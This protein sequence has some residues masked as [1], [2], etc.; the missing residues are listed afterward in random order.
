[1]PPHSRPPYQH[2]SGVSHR[3]PPPQL[4]KQPP[5]KPLAKST[6]KSPVKP[7]AD[8]PPLDKVPT[9]PRF[10]VDPKVASKWSGK[11]EIEIKKSWSAGSNTSE[12]ADRF[13]AS[14]TNRPTRLIADARPDMIKRATSNQNETVE[15]K[16]DLKGPS[17]KR[18]ALNRDSSA[19]ANRLK[20]QYVPGFKKQTFNADREVR[21]LSQNLEQSWPGLRPEPFFESER[22]SSI[23]TIAMELIVKPVVFSETTR[24]STIEALNLDLDD[25]VSLAQTNAKPKPV[26]RSRTMEEVFNDLKDGIL[27]EFVPK[28]STISGN[29]RLTTSDYL[30]IITEPIDDEGLSDEEMTIDQPLVL[31][32]ENSLSERWVAGA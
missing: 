3:P 8:K 23:D 20:E 25:S 24:S 2:Q 32:R 13:D 14:T 17:V 15:T 27:K 19:A 10:D 9:S 29:D 26:A 11:D 1:M 18:A 30:T 22:M 12:E 7:T 16:P 5:S 28:P 4:Q 6:P 21:A 31:S